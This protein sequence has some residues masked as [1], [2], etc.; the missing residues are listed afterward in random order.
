MKESRNQKLKGCQ[1][2]MNNHQFLGY[3]IVFT[4]VQTIVYV[5]STGVP[6]S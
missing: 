1:F 5:Y 3:S 6:K 2:R 4:P